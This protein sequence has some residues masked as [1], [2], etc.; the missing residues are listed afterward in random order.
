[1]KKHHGNCG[2]NCNSIEILLRL[3]FET[4]FEL[5]NKL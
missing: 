4:H 1:M 2:H 3:I 5:Q